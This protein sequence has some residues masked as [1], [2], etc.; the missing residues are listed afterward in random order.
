MN[1]T[2]LSRS[3]LLL[4]ALI[5][6]STCR[7]RPIVADSPAEEL[8][9]KEITRELREADIQMRPLHNDHLN[10]HIQETFE[11]LIPQPIDHTDPSKGM[12]NQKVYLS[13]AS[14]SAPMVM[15]LSGY[16]VGNNRYISEP[17]Y[18]LNANQIHVEHRFFGASI[19]EG[20]IP[21]AYLTIEQAAADHHR[22]V[23]LL[24]EVY[25]GS[26]VNSGIS[27][28]GQTTMYHRYFYPEDVDASVV[29]VAPLNQAREDERIY[30]F[31]A[32]VGAEDCRKKVLA[33][34]MELLLNYN[35]CYSLFLEKTAKRGYTYGLSTE[36]AFELSIFEY[37][38]AF[39]QWSADCDAIPEAGSS[40]ESMIDH[41][42]LI[43]AP[44]F[45][46][47][48]S[49]TDIFPFFYQSYT[50][51]GM[52][53][54]QIEQF[55]G[56]TKE[57]TSNLSNYRTFIPETFDLVYDGTVHQQVKEWL[58]S[59][60]EDMVFIYGEYDPWSATGYV[61]NGTNNLFRFTIPEGN[62]GSRLGHLPQKE[63]SRFSDSLNVWINN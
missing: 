38:F 21:Y 6:L 37:G 10:T 43:D 42:F 63:F 31:L 34:Q 5:L 25:R 2:T 28:G 16:A 27:K 58:D 11:L 3:G 18:E 29:Y 40:F 20:E 26:W 24:K 1:V 45:F 12:F 14:S 60:A 62:H 22:I 8:S 59:E 33:Y 61:P 52:Y 17:T 49:M 30:E 23:S 44:G 56:L 13:H 32:N 39:W 53:G 15:F 41:L 36:R 54:Y 9:I 55:G 4:I 48:S 57:Y 46:T 19:P 50:E 7:T 35:Q 47:A 51:M